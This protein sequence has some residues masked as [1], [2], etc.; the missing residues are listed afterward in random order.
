[1]PWTPLYI[2]LTTGLD[3]SKEAT[4]GASELHAAVNVDFTV[5]GQ[6]RGRPA[7]AARRPPILRAGPEERAREPVTVGGGQGDQGRAGRP[8][9]E[10]PP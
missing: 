1:M 3:L 9:V 6:L 4:L 8:G 7:R 2:P 5:D 10:A